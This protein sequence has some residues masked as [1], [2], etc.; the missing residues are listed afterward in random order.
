[1]IAA[2]DQHSL[3][4]HVAAGRVWES[5]GHGAPHDT[6][7]KVTD[8]CRREAWRS[9]DVV[10]LLGSPENVELIL[11]LWEARQRGELA[12]VQ[13]ASPVLC[14]DR[15]E[16]RDPNTVFL[17]MRSSYLPPSCGGWHSMSPLDY[18]S[19]ALAAALRASEGRYTVEVRNCL[20][21]H[22]VWPAARFPRFISRPALATLLGELLDPRWY[23]DPDRPNGTR[24]LLGFLGLNP[25]TQAG[26][27]SLG[28]PN[29]MHDRC[30]LVHRCWSRPPL[31]IGL[32]YRQDWR[33][34]EA[35]QPGLA[36]GDDP[37]DFLWR[38][39][40]SRKDPVIGHVRASQ[41]FAIFL[42]QTWLQSLSQASSQAHE[43]FVPE[44]YF[45]WSSE[46]AAFRRHFAGFDKAGL[47]GLG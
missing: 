9:A 43:V 15:G 33:P 1:M 35:S 2:L 46:S 34:A 31:H 36:I 11:S 20:W 21:A 22:P 30:K 17:R 3:K 26:V 39:C 40:Y 32:T 18:A 25:R 10:R 12:D 4:L 27:M 7:M 28:R 38:I 13:L 5:D 44:H 45:R 37:R 41:Q 19:Y 24:R 6:L 29:P 42:Q 47:G 14:H 8:Y 16:R 23:I